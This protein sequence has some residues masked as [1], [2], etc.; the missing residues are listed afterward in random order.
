MRKKTL[1]FTH[2]SVSSLKSRLDELKN[3][4]VAIAEGIRSVFIAVESLYSMDG[5]V[6]PLVAIV[7]AVETLLPLGNG[8]VI[9][10]EAHSTGVFGERGRGVVCSLGLEEKVFAKLHTFGKA[11]GC[12]GGEFPPSVRLE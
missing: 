12:H 9:V 5:D 8:H 4:D 7:E 3:G 10:D 6:A 2:N 11:I 1:L